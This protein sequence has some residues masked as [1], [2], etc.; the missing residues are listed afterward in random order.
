M[1][2]YQGA[3]SGQINHLAA[4]YT[5]KAQ[6]YCYLHDNAAWLVAFETKLARES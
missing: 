3:D 6:S 5:Q 1:P 4:D 2:D